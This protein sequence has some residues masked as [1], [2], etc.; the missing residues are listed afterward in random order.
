M[1]QMA[2]PRRHEHQQEPIAAKW[3]EGGPK[4]L[5]TVKVGQGVA[6]PVALDGKLYVLAMQGNDDVLTALDADSGTVLWS[7]SYAVA[8]HGDQAPQ[9]LNR[10]NG[11][12]LPE[13]T[14]TIDGDRIYTYGGGGDLVARQL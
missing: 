1:A 13:A 7:Q 12:P 3:P 6:S 14:P 2:R 8:K 9:G 5:W 11:L 10:D 4:K